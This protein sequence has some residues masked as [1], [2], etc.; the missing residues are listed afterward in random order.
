M[1]A[2][3]AVTRLRFRGCDLQFT[4]DS[5]Q[6]GGSFA[7]VTR[8]LR[9]RLVIAL[10][11]TVTGY[12]TF[13]V[14]LPFAF[15]LYAFVA[16]FTH[17]YVYHVYYVPVVTVAFA[18]TLQLRCVWFVTVTFTVLT[19]CRLLRSRYAR[20][21]FVALRYDAFTH[22]YAVDLRTVGY[23]TFAHVI[24]LCLRLRLR[25]VTRLFTVTRH[26]VVYRLIC[27]TLLVGWLLPV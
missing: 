22:V 10:L 18:F 14:C 26:T 7:F 27:H 12:V 8:L 21:P 15:Q 24:L 17:V 6:C 23:Y 4:V 11:F 3:I 1:V 25:L 5:L 16:H 13:A 2:H 19:V 9:L 20:A